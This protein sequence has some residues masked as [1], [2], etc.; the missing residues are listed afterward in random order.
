VSKT[1]LYGQRALQTSPPPPTQQLVEPRVSHTLAHSLHSTS[2]K[3]YWGSSKAL[4][5][6]LPHYIR[7][8]SAPKDTY[9]PHPTQ[10]VSECPPHSETLSSL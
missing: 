10:R 7:A 4:L 9:P 1:Q 5:A 2:I 8:H 6:V 3:I